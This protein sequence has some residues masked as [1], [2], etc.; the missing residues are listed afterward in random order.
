MIN[1]C[2]ELMNITFEDEARPRGIAADAPKHPVQR[3]HRLVS[4]LA[5]PAG[6]GV[7]NECRLEDGI[8]HRENS[9]MQD[10]ILDCRLVNAPLLGV[11]DREG[12]IRLMLI[13]SGRQLPM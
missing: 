13:T 5:F 1:R 7:D 11:A 8:E 3:I 9:M 10:T 2:E 6:E 4:S 12:A